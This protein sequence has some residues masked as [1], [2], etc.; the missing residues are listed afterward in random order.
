MARAP[1]HHSIPIG[2]K[3]YVQLRDGTRLVAKF[4]QRNDRFLLLE[5]G[6]RYPWADVAVFSPW[7]RGGTVN[8][9]QGG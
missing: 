4:Q 9:Q 3:A 6:G 2:K 1:N 5:G 8:G 7:R